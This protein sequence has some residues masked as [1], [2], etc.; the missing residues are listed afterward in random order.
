[1]AKKTKR[2]AK[3]P[4]Q[5][6][7]LA[8][9]AKPASRPKRV[10]LLPPAANALE[11]TRVLQDGITI[12]ELGLVELK[13]TPAEEAVCAEPVRV[14]HVMVKPNGAPYLPHARYT[15]WLNR[16]FGR[17]GWALVPVG[18]PVISNS[19]V[20]CPYV[21]HIHKQP[22][23]FAMGEQEYFESNRD[24]TYGDALESTVASALRRCCKRLGIGPELWDR[25]WIDEFLGDHCIKVKVRGKKDGDKPRRQWRL[26]SADPFWNEIT[27]GR[28][29]GRSDDEDDPQDDRRP[30]PRR[31]GEPATDAHHSMADEPIT[32]GQRQRF[33]TIA[34]RAGRTPIELST[35]L[36][37][38]YGL[39]NSKLM[40]RRDYDAACRMVEAPGPLP[41][42]RK[43]EPGEEG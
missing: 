38:R 19:S 33:A 3:R 6:K 28:A 23:A 13:L 5:T 26:R 29:G 30:P 8:R 12:G 15:A 25:V 32:K 24:Q 20:V 11:P 16:A 39:D 34:L 36:K 1:V 43:R 2:S 4:T 27:G 14:E 31:A 35:W 21:L 41:L 40:K 42:E 22:V 9:R 37:S 7:A 10:E 18:K 17:L